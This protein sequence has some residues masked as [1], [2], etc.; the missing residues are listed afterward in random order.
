MQFESF[1]T[2][3]TSINAYMNPYALFLSVCRGIYRLFACLGCLDCLVPKSLS[4]R[5]YSDNHGLHLKIIDTGVKR[6]LPQ[7]DALKNQ[8]VKWEVGSWFP[9]STKFLANVHPSTAEWNEW[10]SVNTSVWAVSVL[11]TYQ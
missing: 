5:A 1:K 2:R 10:S 11:G 7:P 4:L 6:M 3:K 9:D 8:G